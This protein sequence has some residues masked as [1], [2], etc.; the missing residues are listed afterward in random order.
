MD[1]SNNDSLAMH[2]MGVPNESSSWID[3]QLYDEEIRNSS[4]GTDEDFSD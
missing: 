3:S 2:A 4:F 1:P